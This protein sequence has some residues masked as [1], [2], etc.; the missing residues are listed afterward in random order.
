MLSLILAV[1]SL[2][3]GCSMFK[4]H[5]RVD[6]APFAENTISL[7][8]DISYGL[9]QQHAR[10]LRRYMGDEPLR[11]YQAQWQ[12]MRPLLRGIAVYSLALVTISKS[13]LTETEKL[14]QLATFLDRM[15][16]PVVDA[17]VQV[18][19]MTSAELDDVLA[20][21]RAQKKF[22]DGLRAAQPLV[23]LVAQVAN[24]HLDRI[25][26]LETAAS[27]YLLEQLM[28]DNAEVLDFELLLKDAQNRSFR[29][30]VLLSEYRRSPE[31]EFVVRLRE[32][33]PQLD[34]L[35]PAD[36]SLTVE[37]MYEIEERITYRLGEIRLMKDQIAEDIRVFHAST[38]EMDD[39]VQ[40]A[41]ATLI[42]TRAT[43]WV[44]SRAHARLA[45]GI[46]DP[47]KV[48]MMD[49]AQRALKAALPF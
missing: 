14:D 3:C 9:N 43:I 16:R 19:T 28:L 5:T 17:P 15:F 12:Q 37:R 22:L 47:A 4:S 20:H 35:L 2:N 44:W 39:L 27:T 23:D 13:D 30:L 41:S 24:D 29:S 8:A 42:K 7:V 18:M 1:V 36:D 25:K 31:P 21:I 38:S 48:D 11:A 33:D 6:M 10:H 32:N 40:G 34:E 26:D 49:I 45:A 46:T